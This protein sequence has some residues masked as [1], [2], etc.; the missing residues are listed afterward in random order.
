MYIFQLTQRSFAIMGVYPN[1]WLRTHAFNG[2]II[3]T[4]FIYLSSCILFFVYFFR[5]ANSFSQYVISIYM[6]SAT[7]V[8]LINFTTLVFQSQ[9]VFEFIENIEKLIEK[10]KFNFFS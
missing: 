5:V 10:S 9:S 8:V 3:K 1:L 6:T 7:V 2:N 4:Y